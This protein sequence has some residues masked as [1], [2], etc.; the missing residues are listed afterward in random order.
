VP[1]RYRDDDE[2][3]IASVLKKEGYATGGL[4]KWEC[5]GR[6]STGVPE[7]HGFDVF[8]GYYDQ[9]H[10]HTYYPPYLVRNSEEVPLPGNHGGSGGKTYSQY[11][12]HDAGLSSSAS[13]PTGRSSRTCCTPRRTGTLTS[14]TATRRGPSTRTSRGRWPPAGTRPW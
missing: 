5:G 13:T 9:V 1:K 10:A 7:K 11:V 6:G 4:G 2:E 3:T 8:L 14:P 12:I